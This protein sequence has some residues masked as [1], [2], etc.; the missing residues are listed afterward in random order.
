MIYLIFVGIPLVVGGWHSALCHFC[1]R[2]LS[3]CS[4]YVVGQKTKTCLDWS[5]DF[6]WCYE[7]VKY[8]G[9]LV[10]QSN[11]ERGVV[12]ISDYFWQFLAILD[13]FW[14]SQVGCKIDG[15]S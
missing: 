7:K 9:T 8:M 1:R 6:S 13:N 12:W 14:N 11:C 15:N 10:D 5:T 4:G 3:A 2:R